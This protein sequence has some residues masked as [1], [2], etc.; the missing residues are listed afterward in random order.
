[1]TGPFIN[2]GKDVFLRPATENG[3]AAHPSFVV[4]D[5][6]RP[7]INGEPVTEESHEFVVKKK[8]ADD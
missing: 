3:A 7:K 1:M 5:D 8:H 6:E 4:P 2:K